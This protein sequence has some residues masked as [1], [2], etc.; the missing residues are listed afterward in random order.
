[1]RKILETLR[2]SIVKNLFIGRNK[3]IIGVNSSH[4]RNGRHLTIIAG[5]LTLEKDS[6]SLQSSFLL[7]KWLWV[8]RVETSVTSV[9]FILQRKFVTCTYKVPLTIF[10]K[11][12][13]LFSF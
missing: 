11:H 6:K 9:R 1:M 8:N 13:L 3:E 12:F 5:I 4:C 7:L 10:Q 2:I